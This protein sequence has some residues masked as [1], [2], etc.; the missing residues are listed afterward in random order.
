MSDLLDDEADET[1]DDEESFFADSCS[2]GAM[3]PVI[4]DAIRSCV[5][6]QDWNVVGVFF[7]DSERNQLSKI[8]AE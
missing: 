1:D 4:K 8:F 5:N 7:I 3:I 2:P 6:H